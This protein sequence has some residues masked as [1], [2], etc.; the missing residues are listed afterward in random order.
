MV[1]DDSVQYITVFIHVLAFGAIGFAIMW[2]T[3]PSFRLQT[4][5]LWFRT[6]M[7]V[8]GGVGSGPGYA[9]V[10]RDEEQGGGCGGAIGKSRGVVSKFSSGR[11]AP[12]RKG[13]PKAVSPSD[14]SDDAED[15]DMPPPRRQT[16]RIPRVA[17]S[18]EEDEDF[19]EDEEEEEDDD[20]D[21]DIPPKG[22]RG[23]NT[24]V[25]VTKARELPPK[26]SLK[27]AARSSAP[28]PKPKPTAGGKK[29]NRSSRG[30]R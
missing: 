25:K 28:K 6:R 9:S 1:S 23:R 4:H 21:E 18:S 17:E 14:E 11:T 22:R 13:R 7:W 2:A 5:A 15:D 20:S 8:R 24:A 30:A 12:V 26:A 16:R 27:Q 3:T 29:S 19:V 10:G